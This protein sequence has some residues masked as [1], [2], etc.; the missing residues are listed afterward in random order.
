ML[1]SVKIREN[2]ESVNMYLKHTLRQA[3]TVLFVGSASQSIDT[4]WK[5]KYKHLLLDLVLQMYL[6]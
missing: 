4:I 1:N 3:S 6:P 5:E 2:M